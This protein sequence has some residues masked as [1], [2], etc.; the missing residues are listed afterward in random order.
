MDK[1][2][3][4]SDSD[5][6]PIEALAIDDQDAMHAIGK[7]QAFTRKFDF[8]SALGFTVCVNA[9]VSVCRGKRGYRC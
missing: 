2:S 8:W 9:T 4:P 5:A 7:K 1:M 3:A 6:H